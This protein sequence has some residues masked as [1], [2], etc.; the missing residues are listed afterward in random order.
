LPDPNDCPRF[1]RSFLFA[2]SS[3]SV[4]CCALTARQHVGAKPMNGIHNTVCITFRRGPPVGKDGCVPTRLKRL[5][6]FPAIVSVW[7]ELLRRRGPTFGHMPFQLSD[8]PRDKRYEDAPKSLTVSFSEDSL[9][10][11]YRKL[12]LVSFLLVILAW[13]IR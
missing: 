3:S 11:D 10:E 5:L 8:Y 4:R 7:G 12:P 6:V 1:E 9:N 2:P 13:T